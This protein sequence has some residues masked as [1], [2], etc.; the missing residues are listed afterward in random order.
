MSQKGSD[1]EAGRSLLRGHGWNR[2]S[3][4]SPGGAGFP[5]EAALHAAGCGHPAGAWEQSTGLAHGG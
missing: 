1:S 5:P 3:L 2:V 4:L